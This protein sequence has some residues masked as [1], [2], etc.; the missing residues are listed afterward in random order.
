MTLDG[1]SA[2][3]PHVIYI[4]VMKGDRLM[5][6][7]PKLL[8]HLEDQVGLVSKR[9]RN[10]SFVPHLTVAFRDLK[11]TCSVRLGLCSS[12]RKFISISL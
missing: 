11:P 3:A 1:F 10:R 4:D 2:F 9:D 6:L 7:Q 12:T 5:N 8:G